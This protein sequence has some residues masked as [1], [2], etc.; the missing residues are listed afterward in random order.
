MKQQVLRWFQI[1]FTH[2]AP[3]YQ[4]VTPLS[5]LL[6]VKGPMGYFPNKKETLSAI[7]PYK[8]QWESNFRKW[9]NRWRRERNELH[10]VK[11]NNEHPFRGKILSN[12]IKGRFHVSNRSEVIEKANKIDTSTTTSWTNKNRQTNASAR[13]LLT[14]ITVSYTHLTLPTK[15]IV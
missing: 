7:F 13:H 6:Q 15:R 10:V 3:I 8:L 12:W 5:K 1:C 2:K 14:T 11:F 4:D 9:L